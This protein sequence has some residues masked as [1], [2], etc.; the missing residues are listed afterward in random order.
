MGWFEQAT[1]Q[2]SGNYS[3]RDRSDENVYRANKEA[4]GGRTITQS[5]LDKAAGIGALGRDSGGNTVRDSGAWE[6]EAERQAAQAS[7]SGGGDYIDMII[8]SAFGG[9]AAVPGAKG[10]PMPAPL[11]SW[12]GRQ[13]VE[14]QQADRR[15]LQEGLAGGLSLEAIIGGALGGGAAVLAYEMWK[16]NN[17]GNAHTQPPDAMGGSSVHPKGP[18]GPRTPGGAGLPSSP[19]PRIVDGV[20]FE[21]D[22]IEGTFQELY[23]QGMLP[24]YNYRD[25]GIGYPP[26]I[27][28]SQ[29]RAQ[30][31]M[32]YPSNLPMVPGVEPE[33]RIPGLGNANANSVNS[34]ITETM[35][36][37][38]AFDDNYIRD[39]GNYM[40]EQGITRPEDIGITPTTAPRL[41]EGL[42][43]A[44]QGGL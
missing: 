28:K 12:R 6:R 27:P 11:P 36:T 1:G 4:M 32:N 38:D 33:K 44:I 31:N 21:T 30:P 37:D 8:D 39:F 40:R 29:A 26:Q 42:T 2:N 13:T 41:W 5:N 15:A 3:G 10:A 16:S 24:T 17:A 43:K 20:P 14:Q 22:I 18:Q 19:R 34:T 25:D 23:N 7:Q 35:A 9:G